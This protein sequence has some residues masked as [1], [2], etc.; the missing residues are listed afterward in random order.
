MRAH[1][2]QATADHEAMLRHYVQHVMGGHRS[3]SVEL[4]RPAGYARTVGQVQ[5]RARRDC[6]VESAEA[7][8]KRGFA[9]TKTSTTSTV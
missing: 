2:V 3:K 1:H 6:Q 7:S 4:S 5:I 9:S 8:R